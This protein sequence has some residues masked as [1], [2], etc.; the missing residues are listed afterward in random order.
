M[1]WAFRVERTF[2]SR[3][4]LGPCCTTL[5]SGVVALWASYPFFGGLAGSVLRL[6]A[7]LCG[8]GA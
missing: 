4:R 2:S 1:S 3:V 8:G 5:D 6:F 7:F